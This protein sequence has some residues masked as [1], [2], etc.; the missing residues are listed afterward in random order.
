MLSALAVQVIANP[1]VIAHRGASGYLPE[2]TLEAA[3]LAYN[4]GSDYI[5][6]DLVLSR[7][8]VPVVLHDIYLDTVTNVATR[9]PDRKRDDGRYYVIDFDLAELKTLTVHERRKPD[10]EQVFPNRYQGS[11]HFTIATFEE[12]IE[13][14]QNLNRLLGRHIGMYPEIKAPA[15]HREAGHEISRIVIEIIRK[16]GLDRSD[17]NVYLQC[18]DFNEIRRIAKE[19]RPAL[20][21]VQLIGYR[22]S[23]T[24]YEH[25]RTEAGV[26]EMK[27]FVR[28]VGPAIPH[29]L[30]FEDG[31]LKPS[32]FA[33]HLARHGLEVHPYTH[34]EDQLPPGL[35]SDVLLQAL[36][37][38][39][40]TGVFTDFP[41]VVRAYID[42][43]H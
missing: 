17:A 19:F 21:L 34:R 2:H 9:F 35:S 41:D 25:L 30:S 36:F 29:M 28:G 38:S 14:I 4:M 22:S 32:E 31:E 20:P 3:A 24:D 26:K 6:Q 39:G 43:S 33:G 37:E 7:D 12:H 13:L 40:A 1:V 15:W 18:F 8:G 10:G 42:Q 16:H 5:E 23:T 27:E 11:G